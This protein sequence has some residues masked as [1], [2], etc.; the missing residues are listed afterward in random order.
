MFGDN[1]MDAADW[2]E[3]NK[4]GY[5]GGIIGNTMGSPYRQDKIDLAE[6]LNNYNNNAVCPC[7]NE[8]CPVPG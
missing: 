7:N 2:W 1:Y 3:L 6:Y 8:G 5:L 4:P